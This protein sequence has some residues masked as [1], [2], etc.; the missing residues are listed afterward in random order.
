MDKVDMA[1]W[2]GATWAW[3]GEKGMAVT[4]A[5]EAVYIDL[6]SFCFVFLI[7]KKNEELPALGWVQAAVMQHYIPPEMVG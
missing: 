7:K 4:K 3:L 2:H 1:R 5:K 6:D